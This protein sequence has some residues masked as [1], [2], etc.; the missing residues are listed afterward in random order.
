MRKHDACFT[1]ER[2]ESIQTFGINIFLRTPGSMEE[3]KAPTVHMPCLVSP[4][5]I[6]VDNHS[7]DKQNATINCNVLSNLF[8]K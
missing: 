2:R 1:I 3:C 8:A 7:K 6:N 5:N 4:V